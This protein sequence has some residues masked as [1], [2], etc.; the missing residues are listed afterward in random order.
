MGYRH[1]REEILRAA[2]AV[3]QERGIAR[4]TFAA[5]GGRLNISD[6]TVVYYFPTKEALVTAVILALGKDLE[7]LLESAFGSVRLSPTDLIRRAW[8]VMATPDAD[9][10][11]ALY[12]EIVGLAA[13]GQ[14]PFDALAQALMRGWVEWLT[15]RTLGTEA[16]TQQSGALAAI[17]QLDGLLLVR[18]LLGGEAADE[19]ARVAGILAVGTS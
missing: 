4:L 17:A 18:H 3:A 6:R 12:F 11:M 16:E 9:R 7:G 8:P 15:P 1:S 2:I 14:S 10:T 5:V 13:A 19:A